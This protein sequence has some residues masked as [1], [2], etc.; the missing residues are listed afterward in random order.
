MSLAEDGMRVPQLSL[1]VV[2]VV[3]FA[4]IGLAFL[5]GFGWL[6]LRS[7]GGDPSVSVSVGAGNPATSELQLDGITKVELEAPGDLVVEIGEPELLR[8]D[9]TPKTLSRLT[10]EVKGDRLVIHSRG[11]IHDSPRFHVT[12]K[13]LDGLTLAGSGD[14]VAPDLK[15][16]EVNVALVGSG[17]LAAGHLEAKRVRLKL[18]ASGNGKLAGIKAGS[19]EVTSVGS[20]NLHVGAGEVPEQRVMVAGSGDYEAR[21][22]QSER[23]TASINGSG[24]V[25]VWARESLKVSINGSGKIAYRGRPAIQQ[26]ILG[27][28]SVESIG[29]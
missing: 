24:D 18:A 3:A 14:V 12:V 11:R 20:G 16:E 10:T 13:R 22:L 9:A 7:C 21:Q 28:G 27:S 1:K 29:D 19:L 15:G 25:A 23:V 6:A 4:P 17:E 8:I 2:A 26:R 5:L